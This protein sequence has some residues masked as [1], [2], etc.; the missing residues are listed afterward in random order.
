[1]IKTHQTPKHLPYDQR[2][3]CLGLPTFE[4]SKKGADMFEVITDITKQ[5]KHYAYLRP[6]L[7]D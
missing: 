5:Q 4:Y 3:C 1:M 2:L 6:Q 7:I